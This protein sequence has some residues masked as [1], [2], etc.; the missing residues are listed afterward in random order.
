[1][2]R[3]YIPQPQRIKGLCCSK[4]VMQV[5]LSFFALWVIGFLLVSYK[6]LGLALSIFRPAWAGLRAR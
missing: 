1:M 3:D 4:T 2:T 5:L 6:F